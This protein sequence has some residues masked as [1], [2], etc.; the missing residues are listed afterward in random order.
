MVHSHLKEKKKI[1]IILHFD[2]FDN[3]EAALY[4]SCHSHLLSCQ[5]FSI[6][7]AHGNCSPYKARG[8]S[9][10]HGCVLD[11]SIYHQYSA[12]ILSYSWRILIVD[13]SSHVK[14]ETS[15]EQP[16]WVLRTGRLIFLGCRW[17]TLESWLLWSVCPPE[18]RA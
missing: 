13:T 8:T 2:N 12:I 7:L 17:K 3:P 6:S 9:C 16:S 10:S 1:K 5:S 15:V 18:A 11:S 14:H 4:G